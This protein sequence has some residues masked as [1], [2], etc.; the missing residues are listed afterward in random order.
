MTTDSVKYLNTECLLTANIRVQ[1]QYL[2]DARRPEEYRKHLHDQLGGMLGAEIVDHR[3]EVWETQDS[4]TGDYDFQAQV[5]VLSP[6]DM[7]K[8]YHMIR[9]E[10]RAEGEGA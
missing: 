9:E 1:K 7:R 8:L 2:E 4:R 10:V 5:Y 6:L 3:A